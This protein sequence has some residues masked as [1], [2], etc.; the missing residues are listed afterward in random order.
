MSTKELQN[1]KQ[2]FLDMYSDKL[3]TVWR[4]RD[5]EWL[6]HYIRN[7]KDFNKITS[8]INGHLDSI[9]VLQKH[10]SK[11][12]DLS[13]KEF[14]LFEVFTYLTLAEGATCNALNYFSYL[15]VTMGHDLFIDRKKKREKIKDNIK[16]IR[17]VKMHTKIRFLNYNGF[18]ALTKEYDSTL[19]N[20]IAHFNFRT[21][22]KGIVW[23]EGEQVD[24]NS[25]IDSLIKIARF[26]KDVFD[27]LYKRAEDAFAKFKKE[28]KT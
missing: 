2:R 12:R 18:K 24:L 19:R 28:V 13:P 14:A 25:K 17:K 11:S 22:E 9:R 1:L 3:K 16:K 27:E 23:I 4:T 6:E 20:N 7:S 21:D 26:T 10:L 5:T 15:L 8:T